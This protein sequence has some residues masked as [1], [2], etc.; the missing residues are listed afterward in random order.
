VRWTFAVLA[1]FA[2][3]AFAADFSKGETLDFT[4]EFL[5][6]SAG[7]A[8]MTIGPQSDN[9]SHYWITSVAESTAGFSHVYRVR[10]EL[11][12]IVKR[13]NFST[14]M[15]RKKL[16]E[17]SKVKD[18][19]TTIQRGQ[20]T[21]KGQQTAVPEPVLDPLSI[22]FYFRTLPLAPGKTFEMPV[23]ADGKLY[24]LAAEV[25]GTQRITT[26][27]GT[28]DALVVEPK[29]EMAGGVFRDEKNKMTIWYSPDDRHLPL[30][31]KSDLKFGSIT[32]TL[33][34]VG[35][36]GVNSSK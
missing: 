21:R 6:I 32:A 30:K 8:R 4:L 34:K 22:L 25:T 12:S 15:Y 19:T 2:T 28:F 13:G 14:T 11:E 1:L 29:S 16:S 10:D 26:P 31:I 35:S 20:A 17:G 24:T 27:L 5:S 18:E 23:I 33:T 9:A 36:D 3:S 7:T